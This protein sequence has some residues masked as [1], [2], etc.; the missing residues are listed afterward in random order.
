MLV[1]QEQA[2][3]SDISTTQRLVPEARRKSMQQIGYGIA[4]DASI[5][6]QTRYAI[7]IETRYQTLLEVAVVPT[8]LANSA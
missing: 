3:S 2:P 7:E 8:P 1:H 4:D 5:L 6:E